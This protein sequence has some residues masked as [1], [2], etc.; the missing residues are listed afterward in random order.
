MRNIKPAWLLALLI[1]AIPLR[2]DEGMWLP[3][4]LKQL[5]EDAMI[6]KG[7]KIPVS[8]LYNESQTSLKDAVVI[9]GGGCTGE[10]ISSTGLVLTN[11][12][13]GYGAIQALSSVEKDY[14]THGYWAMKQTEELPCSGLTVTFIISIEEVTDS[15]LKDVTSGMSEQDREK[16][17]R[18][19][20]DQLIAGKIKNTHY[21]AFVRPFFNGNRYFL[22]VTEVFKDIR[23]AGAPP[24]SIGN[25]GGD[26][27]NWM[28]PRHTGDF[29]LFRIYAGKDNKPAAYSPDNVPYRPK[30]HF[31]ISLQGVKEGDFTM[32]Y[33]FPGRTQQYLSSYAIDLIEQYQNPARIGIR[34]VRLEIMEQGMRISDT[35]RIKYAS[36]QKGLSNAYKK[37]KGELL[38]IR[39]LQ[40]AERKRQFEKEFTNWANASGRSEYAGLPAELKQ[41]YET[42]QPLLLAADYYNEAAMGI[43]LLSFASGWMKWME[44]PPNDTAALNKELVNRKN[45]SADFF[46]NYDARIDQRLF[47]E[48]LAIYYKNTR[49]DLISPYLHSLHKKYGG[50]YSEMAE[51]VFR[52]SVFCSESKLNSLMDRPFKKIRSAVSVDP[53]YALASALSAHYKEKVQIPLASWQ[54]K[55]NMLNRKYM[56]AQMEMQPDKKFYPDANFTLRVTY[57]QVEGYEPRDG[58][59]YHYMTTLDGIMEKEDPKNDEFIVPLKLKELYQ[60]KDFGRYAFN[61]TVPVAFTA[62]NH[63]TGGNSGS[64]VL[65]AYGQL[66]GTN[67]DRVWEGTMSDLHFDPERCRNISVDIRYTLFIVEKFA[68]CRRLV[69]EMTIA[70]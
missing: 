23:L 47:S 15:V 13:C 65:N 59:T 49:S 46:K 68:G 57:G 31:T 56:A 27:D 69:D 21:S 14:L 70:E 17:I 22:F 60:Q 39:R 38:G 48:L 6:K 20:S 32:V 18:N 33:G 34:D 42:A 55:L 2:A 43:E 16:T 28:W 54:E 40:T 35:V 58:V 4:L 66:I 26:T 63:T 52:Q 25:F 64:P 7:L 9:F 24:S 8:D 45:A 12:H 37:W 11:H 29:S 5:N 36:K 3:F 50:R 10:V 51:A 62:S 44:L 1:Y 30:K 61:N 19:K 53:A 67:F 41:A